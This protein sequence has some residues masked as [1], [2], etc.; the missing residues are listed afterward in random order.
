MK[1]R[2]VL[3]LASVLVIAGSAFA[4]KHLEKPYTEW[5]K[6]D[7]LRIVN[8]SAWSKPYQGTIGASN[9]AAGQVFREQ[10]QTVYSG[11]SNPRSVSRDYGP[12]PVTMRLH[13]AMVFRQA[14]VRLQQIEAGYD[15][16]DAAGKAAFDADRKKY[17]DCAICKDYYV[18][19]LTKS[20]DSTAMST[21]EAV[22]QGMTFD[23]L[24]GHIKIVNDKGEEREIVQFNSPK[25]YADKAVFYFKRL[26][27]AGNP[28]LTTDSKT[29]KFV[30]DS[31]ILEPVRNRFAYL[32][33]RT[34]EFKVSKIVVGGKV[35]F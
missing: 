3:L 33:P 11:G 2:I 1:H 15:K 10:G 20:V 27:T 5:G 31:E 8:D 9:A 19:T 32:L 25:N 22:F 17:L 18:I 29:L 16:M 26:D 30:F 6:E 28:L 24:K 34:L 21:E 14:F 35:D 7:S 12:P 4:Q 13:S 23:Q